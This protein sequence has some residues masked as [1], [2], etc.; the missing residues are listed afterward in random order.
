[1]EMEESLSRK[2][3]EELAVEGQRHLEDT[4]AAAYQILCS[5]NQ[6]LCNPS[7]WSTADA[8]DSSHHH[9]PGG[10]ALEDAR[11]RYKCAVAS[12]RAVLSAIPTSHS[13]VPQGAG[14]TGSSPDTSGKKSELQSLEERAAYLRKELANKNKHLK[15]VIDQLRELVM[16]VSM[17]QSPCSV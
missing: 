16:D 15:L 11:H 8:A 6:E 2:S 3:T 14:P 1:M 5:M 7:L 10:G 4:I 9:E 17:W 13:E 12:L